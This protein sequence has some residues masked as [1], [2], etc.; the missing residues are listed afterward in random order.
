MVDNS[1]IRCQKFM[2]K[3]KKFKAFEKNAENSP[4]KDIEW[5][6]EE[7]QAHSETKLAQDIGV[8]QLVDIKFFDFAAD[9]EVFKQH[10][11]TAQEL[12]DTHKKG[13]LSLL[14]RDGLKPFEEV[15]PR[16]IFSRNKRYYRFIIACVSR[17]G[18]VITDTPRTLTQLLQP[19]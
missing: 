14:W 18:A 16:L 19:V 5:E 10:K 3:A 7:V 9:F 17:V 2:N 8:G 1:M 12:F 11:P 13:I 6:G 4:V 15:E